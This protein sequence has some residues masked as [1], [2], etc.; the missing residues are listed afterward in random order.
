MRVVLDT[1]VIIAAFAARGL[2]AEIFEV[3]LA[4]HTIIISEH[5]LSEVHKNLIEKIH[6][7][8]IVVQDIVKYLKDTGELFK[9]EEL[10]KLICRD[11]EDNKILGAALSGNAEFIIT[12]DNDLLTLKKYKGVE[13]ITPREYWNFLREQ[14][15]GA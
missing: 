8:R 7:P 15:K 3:C 4:D 9:P 5:I 10:D 14:T 6:L 13:I 11:K 2:C 12:G 1:N